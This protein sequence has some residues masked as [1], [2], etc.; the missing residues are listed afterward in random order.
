MHDHHIPC[1]VMILP[2]SVPGLLRAYRHGAH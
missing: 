2:I 1:Q